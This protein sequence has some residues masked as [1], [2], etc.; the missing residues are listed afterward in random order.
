DDAATDRRG[1]ALD[2]GEGGDLVDGLDRDTAGAVLLGA[3]ADV[4]ALG[5]V[6]E[7]VVEGALQGVGE[8]ERTGDEGRAEHHGEHGQGEPHLVRGE[9]AQ[10][11]PADGIPTHRSV[12]Y[13]ATGAAEAGSNCFIL[14]STRS[15]VGSRI[16]STMRPSARNTTRSA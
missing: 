6:A 7:D 12:S 13:S 14:S 4:D 9:V 10:G 11:N 2:A 8:D 16:S 3:D 15:A 5:D 1:R